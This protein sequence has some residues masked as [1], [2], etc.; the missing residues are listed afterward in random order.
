M[1]KAKERDDL[2]TRQI[3]Q[4][5]DEL[6]RTGMEQAQPAETPVE[7]NM[8]DERLHTLPSEGGGNGIGPPP[9]PPRM[10]GAQNPG[11][12]DP[13]DDESYYQALRPRGDPPRREMPNP[14]RFL[15]LQ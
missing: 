11:D 6:K 2:L 5:A 15:R 10:G 12:D 8:A 3:A 7:A 9:R 1:A 13:D 14:C 4:M